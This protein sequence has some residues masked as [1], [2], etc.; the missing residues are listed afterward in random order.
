MTRKP[1]R[2]VEDLERVIGIQRT[3]PPAPTQ[4]DIRRLERKRLGPKWG[5]KGENK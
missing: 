2:T 5:K 1:L 4:A 3:V